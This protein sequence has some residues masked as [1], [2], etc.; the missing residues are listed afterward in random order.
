MKGKLKTAVACV[1]LAA[2]AGL[3][4]LGIFNDGYA[5]TASKANR[6]CYECV[7]IG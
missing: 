3:L 5:D 2:A 1:L 7:G 4:A 6:V